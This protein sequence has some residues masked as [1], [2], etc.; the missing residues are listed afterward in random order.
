MLH[1]QHGNSHQ[2]Q[3]KQNKR[4]ISFFITNLKVS[5]LLCA[6]VRVEKVFSAQDETV[7]MASIGSVSKVARFF[8]ICP[9]CEWNS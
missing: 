6:R 5:T 4:L 8:R 2:P 9:L 7:E 3:W 1:I